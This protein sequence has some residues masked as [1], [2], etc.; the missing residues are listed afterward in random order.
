VGQHLSPV[1]IRLLPS[2][3]VDEAEPQWLVLAEDAQEERVGYTTKAG[4]DF[5]PSLE[6]ELFAR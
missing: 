3:E 4:C 5:F 2:I 6:K 1:V